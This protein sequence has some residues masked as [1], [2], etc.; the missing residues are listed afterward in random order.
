MPRWGPAD[1]TVLVLADRG[2]YACWRYR[3]IVALGWRPFLRVNLGGSF[4]PTVGRQRAGA[5]TAFA[6]QTSQVRCTLQAPSPPPACSTSPDTPYLP[7]KEEV[8]EGGKG[9]GSFRP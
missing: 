7:W 5:G 2:R 3:Q 9:N 1:G 6:S 8:R 4:V